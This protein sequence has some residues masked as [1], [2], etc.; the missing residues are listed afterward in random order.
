MSRVAT[1]WP[2]ATGGVARPILYL[3][4]R[5]P[6]KK[7]D[8][9]WEY[10]LFSRGLLCSPGL[11]DQRRVLPTLRERHQLERQRKAG[12]RQR[13]TPPRAR[14][15]VHR[16]R[17]PGQV[18]VRFGAWVRVRLRVRLRARVRVGVRF[19]ARVRVSLVHR[20]R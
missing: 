7:T 10:L 14:R 19:R 15:Q 3:L 18:R 1:A 16:E 13:L 5:V 8:F 6:T 20:E 2:W 17:E 12:G 4:Q 9:Y 11:F